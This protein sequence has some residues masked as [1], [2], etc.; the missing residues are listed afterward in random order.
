[1]PSFTAK[2][3]PI[4]FIGLLALCILEAVIILYL[5]RRAWWNWRSREDGLVEKLKRTLSQR[6]DPRSCRAPA[7]SPTGLP[8]VGEDLPAPPAVLS[9]PQG[10]STRIE[11]ILMELVDLHDEFHILQSR[12]TLGQDELAVLVCE[13]LKD[14]ILL[15]GG[16]IIREDSWNPERQRAVEVLPAPPEAAEIIVIETRRSGLSLNAVVLR[17]QEVVIRKPTPNPD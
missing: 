15:S 5:T 8:T 16:E 10:H 2:M 17:K 6:R 7:E 9:S 3:P 13:R 4:F 12:S 11:R 1:M 14:R